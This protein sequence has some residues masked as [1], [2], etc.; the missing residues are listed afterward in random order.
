MDNFKTSLLLICILSFLIANSIYANNQT[1]FACKTGFQF[2]TSNKAARC[3]QQ[4][5][6]TYRSPL[7][8]GHLRGNKNR[9]IL[10]VDKIGHKDMCITPQM[11]SKKQPAI[12]GLIGKRGQNLPI[13]IK[14]TN[15]GAKLSPFSPKCEKGF[16]LHIRRGKDV[17]GK[18]KP[19][20]ILP[21]SKKVRR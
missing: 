13:A 18:D 3:I 19:E 9:F 8:C 15:R 4:K 12:S 10:A 17:C 7:A 11:V 1:Y 14:Q 20:V 16:K 2:E 21:P 6:L 5:R